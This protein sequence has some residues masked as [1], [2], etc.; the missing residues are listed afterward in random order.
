MREEREKPTP[1]KT[2]AS[3]KSK[4][5]KFVIEAF[6]LKSFQG[7]ERE[8]QIIDRKDTEHK[9]DQAYE[10]LEKKMYPNSFLK[11]W[12]QEIRKRDL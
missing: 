2:K 5:K 7:D 8:W 6:A 10:S 12:Y 11:R 3:I 4:D 9:R 1:N